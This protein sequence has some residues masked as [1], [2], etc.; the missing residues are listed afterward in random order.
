[1][2]DQYKEFLNLMGVK[3]KDVDINNILKEDKNMNKE[4]K[5]IK[6]NRN[7]KCNCGSNKKYKK[8]CGK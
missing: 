1:M 2:N 8:C 6:I 4:K 5:Q 7:D 3:Y